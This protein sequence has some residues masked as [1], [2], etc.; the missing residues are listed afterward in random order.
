MRSTRFSAIRLGRLCGGEQWLREFLRCALKIDRSSYPC[1]AFRH[2][3][4][5]FSGF[6]LLNELDTQTA[7]LH[8]CL[9]LYHLHLMEELLAS[10]DKIEAM[11][12]KQV[13]QSTFERWGI[14]REHQYMHIKR[15]WNR[16][17]AEFHNSFHRFQSPCHAI[18]KTP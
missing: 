4:T 10:V 17:S 18:F 9:N 6:R 11:V 8:E 7:L 1:L 16:R 13:V 2:R 5:V 14:I 12:L 3:L 15:E